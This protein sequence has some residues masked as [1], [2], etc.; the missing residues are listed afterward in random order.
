MSPHHHHHQHPLFPFQSL[1]KNFFSSLYNFL[2][3]HICTS[4]TRPGEPCDLH[5]GLLPGRRK[6]MRRAGAGGGGWISQPLLYQLW[7]QR[8]LWCCSSALNPLTSWA[9]LTLSFPPI[10]LS[11][12]VF[13]LFFKLFFHS[14]LALDWP[15]CLSQSLRFT[16]I[17]LYTS[18]ASE[19]KHNIK[20]FA[21]T[22][23]RVKLWV[24]QE[25]CLSNGE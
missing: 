13:L 4:I 5:R 7:G 3:P 8:S 25:L 19:Y 6:R 15:T 20:L 17:T 11:A 9:T 1:T 12:W 21:T 23:L 18:V 2:P 16:V 10:C 22:R 14:F 24:F